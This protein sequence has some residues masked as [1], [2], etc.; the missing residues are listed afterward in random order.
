MNCENISKSLMTVF[1]LF[2]FVE[3][4]EGKAKSQAPSVVLQAMGPFS[5]PMVLFYHIDMLLSIA[6][7]DFTVCLFG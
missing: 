1:P 2:T 4:C 3:R 7:D 5:S 6:S